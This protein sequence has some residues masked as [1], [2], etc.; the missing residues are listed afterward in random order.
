MQQES[1][2]VQLGV[3]CTG[4]MSLQDDVCVFRFGWRLRMCMDSVIFSSAT[5]LQTC[6]ISMVRE[7]GLTLSFS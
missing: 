1:V 7:V 2:Y 5:S 4:G 6:K 3:Y